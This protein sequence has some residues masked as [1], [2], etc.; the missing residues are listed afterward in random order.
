MSIRLKDIAVD[1]ICKYLILRISQALNS[2]NLGSITRFWPRIPRQAQCARQS[3]PSD[4]SILLLR[5]HLLTIASKLP[6]GSV[7]NLLGRLGFVPARVA[8]G[9]GLGSRSE[10]R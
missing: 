7:L 4:R 2:T 3:P 9:S 1:N 6:L 5:V 10:I 8:T